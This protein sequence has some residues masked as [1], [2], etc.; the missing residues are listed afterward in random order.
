M[1]EEYE[2]LTQEAHVLKL[3]DTYIGSTK[4]TQE[5]RWNFDTVSNRMVYKSLAFNPGLYKI[6]DEIIVNARDAFVRSSGEGRVPVKKI[7]VVVSG[8]GSPALIEVLN[9]G[10]GIPI[11]EHEKEKCYIPELIFGHMLTSSNYKEGEKKIVGGKNGFGAK[12]TNIFSTQFTVDTQSV[13]DAKKYVQTW[14]NNMSVK[15][16][17][18]QEG[19]QFQGLCPHRVHARRQA[20]SR[21]LCR[22]WG[23]YR[24]Y[25]TSLP[26]PCSRIGGHGRHQGHLEWRRCA[27]QHL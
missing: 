4:T 18:Y 11:Q 10:D 15:Q 6:F 17:I 23:S 2:K 16:A 14:T 7:D 1:A 13:A 19:H 21:G 12:L 22:G 3:P 9:D 5:K 25:A 27:N 24:G 20:V 8:P 26:H